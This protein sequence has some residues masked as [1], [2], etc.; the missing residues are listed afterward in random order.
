[1]YHPLEHEHSGEGLLST[2]P[3]VSML[4]GTW[5]PETQHYFTNT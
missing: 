4:F 3:D 2:D 5:E 1:M